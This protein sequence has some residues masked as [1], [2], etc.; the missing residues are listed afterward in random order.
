MITPDRLEEL[1][2]KVEIWANDRT[3]ARTVYKEFYIK[4]QIIDDF[5]RANPK[6]FESDKEYD[7]AYWASSFI[8]ITVLTTINSMYMIEDLNHSTIHRPYRV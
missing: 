1:A 5:I 8:R 7:R 6:F 4:F 2:V 3:V